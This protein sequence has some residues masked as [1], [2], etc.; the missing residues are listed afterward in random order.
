[1]SSCPPYVCGCWRIPWL[2]RYHV[3]FSRQCIRT[4]QWA[5][6]RRSQSAVRIH[7]LQKL[8]LIVSSGLFA[9]RVKKLFEGISN[10]LCFS[11]QHLAP[12]FANVV[13][14]LPSALLKLF[15]HAQ[16]SSVLSPRK[17]VNVR[18]D[19]PAYTVCKCE[20][21]E[22]VGFLQD[23]IDCQCSRQCSQPEPGPLLCLRGRVGGCWSS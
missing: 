8:C 17:H 20:Q 18:L 1:M 23:S 21:S 5:V 2:Q 11:Y 6:H 12:S 13:I 3:C 15:C 4:S 16:Y 10:M 22:Y 14:M 9:K 19:P 7:V